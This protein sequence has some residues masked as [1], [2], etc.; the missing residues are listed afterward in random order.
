LH[1]HPGDQWRKHLG[2]SS[3]KGG[4]DRRE[5][6]G[7]LRP[8]SIVL[9][10]PKAASSAWAVRRTNYTPLPNNAKAVQWVTDST[11]RLDPH[12]PQFCCRRDLLE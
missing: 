11:N 5:Q 3:H 1:P 8:G 7:P 2:L 10:R 12:S 4:S 9:T 6:I